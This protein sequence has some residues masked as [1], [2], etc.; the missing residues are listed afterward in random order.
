M[1]AWPGE[2]ERVVFDTRSGDLH[3]LTA[4]AADVLERL[5]ETDATVQ[6]LSAQFP[7]F[8]LDALESLL[9][10]F[11]ALGLIHPGAW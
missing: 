10:S 1:R 4:T 11:D 2:D 6:E 3:L 5:M 8:E 7:S 9:A